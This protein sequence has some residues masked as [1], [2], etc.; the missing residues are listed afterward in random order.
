MHIRRASSEEFQSFWSNKFIKTKTYFYDGII[1][2][3]IEFWVIEDTETGLFVGELYIMWDSVDKEEANG[4]N[5]AYLC[6]YRVNQELQGKG[7][8]SKLLS[9]VLERVAENGFE[10]VT[11][12]VDNDNYKKLIHIYKKHGFSETIKRQ[13]IDQ[14]FLES[15]GLPIEDKIGYDLLLCRLSVKS[16][17]NQIK[18]SKR[19]I[20][21]FSI[22]DM[23]SKEYASHAIHPIHLFLAAF[24]MNHD[25]NLELRNFVKLDDAFMSNL[26]RVF[27]GLNVK[28]DY[29]QLQL[30]SEKCFNVFDST[31]QIVNEA[32]RLTQLFE[33]HGQI[34]LS[35]GQ[36]LRVVMNNEIDFIKDCFLNIDRDLVVSILSTPRDMMV[37]LN[38]E[39]NFTS[40]PGVTIKKASSFD[41]ELI[42]KFVG[43]YFYD[44][45]ANTISIGFEAE[46]IPIYIAL[47]DNEI[48]GFAGYNI[49][50]RRRGYFGPLG[51]L[52]THRDKKIGQALVVSC[53]RDLKR[54]GFNKCIIGNASSFDFYEKACGAKLMAFELTEVSI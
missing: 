9:R 28:E 16:K 4:V 14:H 26:S 27:N 11:I 54:Q 33:E 18:F 25:A 13:F 43:K 1:N 22:A 45:W 49:S 52:K 15:N 53:M 31:Q 39:F 30:D 48:V 20:E 37:D 50:K 17:L 34:Y 42:M 41:E 29:H 6:A 8:G 38:K 51:V 7:L 46:D 32:H 12:G 35:D 5:R 24:R 44:R 23:I 3:S 2:N 36:I 21:L 10:E 40:H 47:V 19:A